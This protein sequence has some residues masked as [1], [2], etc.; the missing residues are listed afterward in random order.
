MIN[1]TTTY[2]ETSRLI[3]RS[4]KP[5]D[6]PLFVAMNMDERV[7]KYFPALLTEEETVAFY[8]RIKNEFD[9]NGWGL[10]AV[11]LK[12]TGQ[13]IGYVGLHEIG[14]DAGFTPGIEI[15]WRL[16]ADYHNRGYATEAAEEVLKLAKS[17]GIKSLYS[18][19]ATINTP[20]ERVM[21]KIRMKKIGEF[22]HPKLTTD[23]PLCRHVLYR[24]AL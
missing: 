23:S 2:A 22:D 18:F 10:Y 7:M 19:T 24:I 16:A 3:L 1:R 6:L 11:E 13:F 14:F 5:E 9:N 17:C 15:G 8:D 12:S 21:Q 4:W 20:S